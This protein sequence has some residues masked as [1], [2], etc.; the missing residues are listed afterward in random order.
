[1]AVI[2]RY[3]VALLAFAIS[4]AISHATYWVNQFP[5]YSSMESCAMA[6]VSAIVRGM[7]AGCGDGGS[8][9]S[10]DCFC[11]TSSTQ[12]VNA[13]AS[14]VSSNCN[15]TLSHILTALAVYQSYC[16]LGK[17]V[18]TTTSE[19]CKYSLMLFCLVADRVPTA[20]ST[21]SSSSVTSTT[22]AASPIPVTVT[23]A[24]STATQTGATV[25]DESSS[26]VPTRLNEGAKA[27]IAIGVVALILAAA[28]LAAF[29]YFRR[30]SLSD[31]P[32]GAGD[33]RGR[34]PFALLD[35]RP[36]TAQAQSQS[37]AP[38]QEA[39]W[40]WQGINKS[41]SPTYVVSEKEVSVPKSSSSNGYGID[42]VKPMLE[43][44]SVTQPRHELS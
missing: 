30:R 11:S 7:T 42:D 26:S 15:G 13:I 25:E 8:Y 19:G 23:S 9:T 27:G 31:S 10:Y 5:L 21:A 2:Y 29:I 3:L 20:S 40:D 1:M 28:G 36:S 34:N 16:D 44:S 14:S 33:S 18:V 17:A 43:G 35:T 39:S 38:G 4:P 22:A 24:A 6:P 12:M 41:P 32:R 37:L